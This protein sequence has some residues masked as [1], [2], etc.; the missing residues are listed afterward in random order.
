LS[1]WQSLPSDIRKIRAALILRFFRKLF[2]RNADGAIGLSDDALTRA[3]N[4][5][6][7]SFLMR[8]AITPSLMIM[9]III[10]PGTGQG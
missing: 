8:A 5:L 6:I 2:H 3:W 4:G 9:A 7:G 1:Q 10:S